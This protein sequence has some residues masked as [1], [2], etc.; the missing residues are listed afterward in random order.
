MQHTWASALAPY[1]AISCYLKSRACK[2][3]Y[4]RHALYKQLC[5]VKPLEPPVMQL[6]NPGMCLA[7]IIWKTAP[8]VQSV[9]HN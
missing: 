5:S 9:C 3:L 6:S 7:C 1:P 8:K 4:P 2:G